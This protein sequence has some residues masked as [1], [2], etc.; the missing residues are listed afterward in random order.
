MPKISVV[1]PTYNGEKYIRESIESIINQ[2]FKDWEL[3]IVND[4]SNDDTL[5]IASEYVKK[6]NRIRIINNQKN[7]K[8]PASLNVGFNNAKGKYYTWTSDDNKYKNTAFEVMYDYLEKNKK[9]QMVCAGM[10]YIDKNGK[11]LYKHIS[12]SDELM[13]YNDCVGACFLYRKTVLDDIG[14]YN[15]EEFC[16]EDYEYWMRILKRYGT[17]GYINKTLYEY[18]V[19]GESLTETK[20]DYINSQLLKFRASEIEWILDNLEKRP[21]LIIRMYCDF[22]KDEKRDFFY[23]KAC[24]KIP[25]L[26]LVKTSNCINKK[27]YIVWGAG[28]YGLIAK[29]ILGE[30]VQ[31]FADTNVN[32]IGST[33][34]GIRIISY[35]EMIS[36]TQYEICIAIWDG[37][38]YDMLKRLYESGVDACRL[39]QEFM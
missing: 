1:L 37:K 8:L 17:I 2:T 28:H 24:K 4:Y 34:E 12:Y 3:I 36:K 23:E 5:G 15:L 26:S 19:H 33:I 32:I 22:I 35:D 27:K 11:F 13:Y 21:D 38:I 18:R 39:I 30:K 14:E 6:D 16:V 25:E 31:Y 7:K 20:K 10:N 9:Y 29:K